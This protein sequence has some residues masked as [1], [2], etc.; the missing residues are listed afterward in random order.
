MQAGDLVWAPHPLNAIGGGR[1][2]AFFVRATPERTLPTIGP[3]PDPVIGGTV[4]V[5][6]ED[7]TEYEWAE[8]GVT[9]RAVEPHQLRLT[10]DSGGEPGVTDYPSREVAVEAMHRAARPQLWTGPGAQPKRDPFLV[11]VLDVAGNV[12]AAERSR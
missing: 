6:Y 3:G 1:E 9:P 4:V 11:E 12:V 2:A 5:K 7:G 8:G 10:M